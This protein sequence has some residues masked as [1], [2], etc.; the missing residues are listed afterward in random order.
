[1][2]TVAKVMGAV[3]LAGAAFAAPVQAQVS[4]ITTGS[5]TGSGTTCNNSVF[6]PTATCVFG[7]FTLLFTNEDATNVGGVASLGNFTLSGANPIPGSGPVSIPAGTM[8]AI[9]INQSAPTVG[10]GVTRGVISGTVQSAP[11]GSINASTLIWLPD[12]FVNIGPTTYELIFDN[13]GPAA[14]RGLA[15]PFNNPQGS[16]RGIQVLVSTVPEPGSMALVAT[17]LLGIFGIARRRQSMK[18]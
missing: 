10:M 12:R 4:Y 8:F 9:M 15:I 5:F 17:G 3:L 14:G 18:A 16:T 1:M 13:A 6:L 2:K 7:G 11:P